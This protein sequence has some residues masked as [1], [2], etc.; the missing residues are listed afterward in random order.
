MEPKEFSFEEQ[1]RRS[2]GRPSRD[3]I[4]SSRVT[5]EELIELENAAKAEGKALSEWARETLLSEA[6]RPKDNPIFTEVVAI[7]TLLNYMLRPIAM[8]E[9][10]TLEQYT[11]ILDNVRDRKRE[12]ARSVMNQYLSAPRKE[13]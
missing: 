5:T 3:R 7:R 11:E 10:I 2:K 9:V 13:Q 4:A 6:R 1:L 12:T 8:G